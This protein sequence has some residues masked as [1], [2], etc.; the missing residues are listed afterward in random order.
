MSEFEQLAAAIAKS[1]GH[2][3]SQLSEKMRSPYYRMA[4]GTALALANDPT[5]Y[6]QGT[7]GDFVDQVVLRGALSGKVKP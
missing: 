5:L 2:E 6:T 4:H 1:D 3:F 7:V